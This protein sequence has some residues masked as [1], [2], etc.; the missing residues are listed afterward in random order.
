[1]FRHK[2]FIWLCYVQ[3]FSNRQTETDLKEFDINKYTSNNSKGNVFEVHLEYPKELKEL[4][5]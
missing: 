2:H 4:I 5:T 1:M 3:I